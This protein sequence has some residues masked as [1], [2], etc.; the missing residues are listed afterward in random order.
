MAEIEKGNTVNTQ[1]LR[2]L[3]FIIIKGLLCH[4]IDSKAECFMLETN[5]QRFQHDNVLFPWFL[6]PEN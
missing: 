3:N 4:L 5:D 1:A 6:H 2:T